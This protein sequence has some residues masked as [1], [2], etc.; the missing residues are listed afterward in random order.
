MKEFLQEKFK[1]IPFG[2]IFKNILIFIAF[3]III[4]LIISIIIYS[5]ISH[6]SKEY[7]YSDSSLIPKN[8]VGLLLGT[9]PVTANGDASKF[10][11]TRMDAA[12]E[13]ISNKKIE[14]I[15]VSGDNRTVSYNEP[16]YMRNHL[17]KLGVDSGYIISDFAGR[18]TLDSVLR[19][20]K[21]FNQN[22]ITIISQKF[23]N[24]RAVFIARK[25]GI[26]AIAFNAE[27]PYPNNLEN[28]FVNTKSFTRELLA[29]NIAIW[30]FLID[31]QPEVLG[32][33]VQIRNEKI[34]EIK[35]LILEK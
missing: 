12:E 35:K 5:Y 17:L 13:L 32:Q 28:I 4:F 26:N 1:K 24:E 8:K 19:S 11:A 14:Y 29:I 23:H 3:L 22:N 9:S 2:K 7:I 15:L 10:F 21:I 30:D 16:K 33:S 27:N 25:N 31:K 20:Y 18:R 34:I 6:Y